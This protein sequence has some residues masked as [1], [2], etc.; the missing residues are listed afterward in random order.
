MIE[1]KSNEFALLWLVYD[2]PPDGHGEWI[3]QKFSGVLAAVVTVPTLEAYDQAYK[4]VKRNGRIVAV[5]LPSGNM[6]VPVLDLAIRG[7]QIIGTLVGTRKDLQEAL[8]LAKIHQIIGN[9]EKRKLEDINEIFDDMR[10]RRI[11]GRIVIDFL[12]K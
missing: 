8:G 6:S 2:G 5:A 9:V 10:S 3:Q 7:I 4:S 12:A 1:N 11:C